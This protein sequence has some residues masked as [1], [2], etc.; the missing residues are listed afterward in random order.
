VTQS[1]FSLEN[2][3]IKQAVKDTEAELGDEGR[4]LLRRSGTEALIRVMVEGEDEGKVTRLAEKLADVV[5]QE[6][7]A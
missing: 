6:F 7:S 5:K 4:V 3:R 2:P 1:D